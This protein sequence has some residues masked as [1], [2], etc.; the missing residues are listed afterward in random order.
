MDEEK[1]LDEKTLCEVTGGGAGGP[2]RGVEL[3][4][5]TQQFRKS[6]CSGCAKD[7]G[8]C[9]HGSADT[10]Y[11][12]LYSRHKGSYGAICPERE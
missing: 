3:A 8:G 6:N 2:A 12:A 9:P 7:S 11:I 4:R 10:R 5:F 1:T